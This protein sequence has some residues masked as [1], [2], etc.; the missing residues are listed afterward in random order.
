MTTAASGYRSPRN[1][2][3]LRDALCDWLR[4][5]G[6][7]TRLVPA[8]CKPQITEGLQH[9]NPKIDNDA[10]IDLRIR[11]AGTDDA[12][13]KGCPNATGLRF[14]DTRTALAEKQHTVPMTVPPPA[15]V[16]AWLD[17]S[18]PTCRH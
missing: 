1:D 3:E 5:N 9:T 15:I 16:R 6:V 18:C 2:S 8:D 13:D 14:N 10:V 11:E 4:A 12:T 17:N 7:D